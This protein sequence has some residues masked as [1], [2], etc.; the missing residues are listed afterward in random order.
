LIRLSKVHEYIIYLISVIVVIS[1]FLWLYF[2]F[3]IRV[4]TEFS[5]QVHPLQNT[6]LILHGSSSII[7]L[8]ALGS[9]LPVHIF[10][11]WKT[12]NNR[13]SGGFFLLLFTILILTGIGLFYSA[14]EDNRRI[15]SVL[16]WVIGILFPIFFVIH[17]YFGKYKK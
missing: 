9:V 8:I 14:V 13:L 12:K 11:A 7:F 17:I 15:L 2:D 10:K 1:G 3:F 4:E 5:L 16:H 6:F